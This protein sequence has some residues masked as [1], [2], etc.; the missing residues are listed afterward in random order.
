MTAE[1]YATLPATIEV[2]EL[3]YW[4]RQRGFRT[5]VVT[6]VTTLLDADLYPLEETGG[7]LRAALGSGNQLR[8]SQDHDADG[9]AALPDGPRRV[10]GAVHVRAGLQPGAAGDVSGG[11]AN[12]TFRTI[13]SASSTRCAG[14]L[15]ACEHR[16]ELE[17]LVN[18]HRP[19]R[20]EPRVKKR[21]P[22]QYGLM[23]QPRC[24]LR[25]Q[26]ATQKLPA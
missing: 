2:R 18:P 19:G 20:Y 13:V 17:L 15:S 26:L 21:R 3:R 25:Q 10:E 16:T 4:T 14:W 12:N 7:S 6:L 22:K 1:Q 9:R 11:H 24:Q 23:R 8:A 5:R